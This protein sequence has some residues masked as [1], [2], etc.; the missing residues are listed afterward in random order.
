MGTF[1][2]LGFF[3]FRVRV[4]GLE[5]REAEILEASKGLGREDL[6]SP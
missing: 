4:K 6:L 1:L 3:G 5:G 2:G